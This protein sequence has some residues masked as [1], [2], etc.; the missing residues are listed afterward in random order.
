[1]RFGIVNYTEWEDIKITVGAYGP[2]HVVLK[3]GMIYMNELMSD[4]YPKIHEFIERQIPE[5]DVYRITPLGGRITTIGQYLFY[6]KK[7]VRNA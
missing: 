4:S 6:I 1:M 7:E 2:G 5:N 3:D